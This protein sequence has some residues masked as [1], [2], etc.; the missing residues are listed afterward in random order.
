M[1]FGQRTRYVVQSDGE[2]SQLL[3]DR[4]ILREGATNIIVRQVAFLEC[5]WDV[6][7]DMSYILGDVVRAQ[8]NFQEG[9]V[10]F[11]ETPEPSC[12]KF[13]FAEVSIFQGG[14]TQHVGMSRELVC[15]N[16]EMHKPLVEDR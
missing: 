4:E 12:G 13:I 8:V 5:G 14:E 15:G 9:M 2:E 1:E 3:L 16:V 11:V 7:E 6:Q 10:R